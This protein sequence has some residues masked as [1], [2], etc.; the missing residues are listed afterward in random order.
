MIRPRRRIGSLLGPLALLGAI[1]AYEIMA[2]P[3]F[4]PERPTASSGANAPV[5]S[6]NQPP[7][8]RRDISGLSE[9]VARPLF[10][11]T[12][13]PL[14]PKAQGKV[15]E[16]EPKAEMPDLI[17]VIIS[18]DTRMVLLR[19]N[20][21]SEVMRAV[22]GQNVW[23]WEVRDIKPTQVV[24]QRGDE[25]ETIKINNAVPPASNTTPTSGNPSPSHIA[26]NAPAANNA[27]VASNPST[28]PTGSATA[29]TA[30]T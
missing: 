26:P 6:P 19:T 12:R 22:E 4:V 11:Q 25:S 7:P 18:K 9:I 16:N 2:G 17:G 28:S 24:V 10:V 27:S 3:F 1:L 29:Q 30:V 8:V 23:G 21:T 20:S 5:V 13:R 14:P 15:A